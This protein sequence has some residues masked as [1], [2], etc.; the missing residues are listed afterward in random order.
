MRFTHSLAAAAA[1]AL[2]LAV[3]A[4]AAPP[5]SVPS[6]VGRALAYI[7]RAKDQFERS[8]A[9]T[10]RSSELGRLERARS[11]LRRARTLARK[12][13]HPI[14]DDVDEEAAPL[15]VTTLNRKATLYLERRSLRSARRTN[16]EALRIAPRDARALR[17]K[18]LIEAAT[19]VPDTYEDDD[20]LR[21]RTYG[22]GYYLPYR[23]YRLGYGR[24]LD[25]RHR[26]RGR[27]HGRFGRLHG[28]HARG[29]GQT[30]GHAGQPAATGGSVRGHDGGLARFRFR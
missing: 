7:E 23:R 3:P 19:V 5:R 18:A 17:L 29:L 15:L 21:Y 13:V 27:V 4:T 16:D 24:L 8:Q 14:F 9:A 12:G 11:Y 22:G 1:L 20:V 26:V 28:R 30:N 2:A 25:R 6:A 10:S